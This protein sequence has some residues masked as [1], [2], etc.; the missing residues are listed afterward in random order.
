V[1]PCVPPSFER[2]WAV[3]YYVMKCAVC[4]FTQCAVSRVLVAPELHHIRSLNPI[5]RGVQHEFY[6]MWAWSV[7]QVSP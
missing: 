1:S 2:F 6:Y 3:A 7:D 4:V 5:D